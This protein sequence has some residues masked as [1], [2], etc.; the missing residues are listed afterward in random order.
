MRFCDL[1]IG[2]RNGS[3][4][5]LK[6]RVLGMTMALEVS[7]EMGL[8]EVFV[9]STVVMTT[10]F[11]ISIECILCLVL[12]RRDDI[13]WSSDLSTIQMSKDWF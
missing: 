3:F 10:V 1:C 12:N 4:C 5:L 11:D 2:E 13:V 8:E 9:V 7:N 6:P